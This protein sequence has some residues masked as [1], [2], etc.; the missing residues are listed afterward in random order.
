MWHQ[1]TYVKCLCWSFSVERLAPSNCYWWVVMIYQNAS[2]AMSFDIVRKLSGK[3]VEETTCLVS[4]LSF[5]NFWLSRLW[6]SSI[7]GTWNPYFHEDFSTFWKFPGS[8]ADLLKTEIETIKGF[9]IQSVALAGL[10][11]SHLAVNDFTWTWNWRPPILF[12][13]LVSIGWWNPNLYLG[14]NCVFHF[15]RHILQKTGPL[16]DS[17]LFGTR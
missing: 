15:T 13:G 10:P 2:S 9:G 1:K 16:S 12:K 7:F 17:Y 4:V 3:R 14:E 11:D 6:V 5:L 8:V